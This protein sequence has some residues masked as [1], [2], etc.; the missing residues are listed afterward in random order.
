MRNGRLIVTI[1][2]F[3]PTTREVIQVD[4][5][6][7]GMDV[8]MAVSLALVER[9]AAGEYDISPCEQSCFS[10]SHRSRRPRERRELVHAVVDHSP[11][12]EVG[13]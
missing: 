3:Y 9:M 6:R 11:R 4:A 2:L 12:F 10:L 7:E 5:A 1:R 13:A 8:R